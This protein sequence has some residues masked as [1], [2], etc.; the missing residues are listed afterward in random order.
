MSSTLSVVQSATAAAAQAAASTAAASAGAA[1]GGTGGQGAGAAGGGAG[2]APGGANPDSLIVHKFDIALVVLLAVVAV[3]FLPRRIAKF[4]A[5][6]ERGLGFILRGGKGV[7]SPAFAD[8]GLR[9]WN[10]SAVTVGGSDSTHDYKGGQ[11]QEYLNPA[12][13]SLPSSSNP[14]PHFPKYQTFLHP[15]SEVI[16]YP[17]KLLGNYSVGKL[18]LMTVYL[19]G[20]VLV[21]FLLDG[22]PMGDP[23]RLGWLAAAQAPIVVGLAL[24][25]SPAGMASG[26]GYEKVRL[27]F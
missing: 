26:L 18:F 12:G 21:I 10:A 17:V 23:V 5:K 8:N 3:I 22:N 2:G 11:S 19:V 7:S 15:V 14:P 27:M 24:K 20:V 9:R 13:Y 16:N 6:S 1:S 25:S 4:M